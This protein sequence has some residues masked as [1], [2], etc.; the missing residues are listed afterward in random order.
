MGAPFQHAGR[1]GWPWGPSGGAT[2]DC[3]SVR[4]LMPLRLSMT[5]DYKMCTATAMSKERNIWVVQRHD[6]V[7]K[8]MFAFGRCLYCLLNLPADCMPIF[9]TQAGSDVSASLTAWGSWQP[10]LAPFR[11]PTVLDALVGSLGSRGSN[12][13]SLAPN[14]H[15][16]GK[17]LC[18]SQH[19]TLNIAKHASLDVIRPI[20]LYQLNWQEKSKTGCCQECGQVQEVA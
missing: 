13:V 17:V 8:C 18:R 12:R 10:A 6:A 15:V 20:H 19:H 1:L 14:Q 9:K 7:P 3:L 5:C 2:P 16:M 11:G 4:Q